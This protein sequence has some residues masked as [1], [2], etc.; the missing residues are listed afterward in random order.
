MAFT[1]AG[2][3]GISLWR[4][5]NGKKLERVAL[6]DFGWKQGWGLT[7]IDFDNDGWL[8][9]VAVGEGAN[10]GEIRLLRNL[11]DAGWADVTKKTQLDS[12]KLNQPRAVAV[13]DL[14]GKGNPDL[15]VSQ[16]AML[17]V[18]LDNIGA[19]QNNWMQIEFKPLNDNKKCDSRT[20]RVN[21]MPV[22]FYQQWEI[23]R[24]FRILKS[25]MPCRWLPAW[26]QKNP[27]MA[28][29]L[30]RP[31]MRATQMKL[32]CWPRKIQS[33]EELDRRGSSCPV[34]FSWNGRE[35]QLI[36]RWHDWPRSSWALGSTR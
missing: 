7:W 23:S 14:R 31:T 35:Y 24:S 21:F 29:R 28:V 22:R 19:N 11:G 30:V 20:E 36:A 2:A 9:L 16:E 10:G 15:I 8:D 12:V 3:P 13:A 34:L 18:I 6:P 17:Q 25:A 4:N 5:V 26:V 32:N 27:W 1:H 33:I